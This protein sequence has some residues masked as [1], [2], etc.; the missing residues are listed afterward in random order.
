MRIT[1]ARQQEPRVNLRIRIPKVR[2]IDQNGNQS[3]ILD[4]KDALKMA[5]DAGLDLVEVAP[6]ERPP[7]CRIM[8]YGRFKYQQKK[9]HQKHHGAQ[10]KGIRLSPKIQDHDLLIKAEHAKGFLSRGDKVMVTMQFRGREMT[11]LEIG[12]EIMQKFLEGLGQSAKI[13]K[14]LQMENRRLNV[15]LAPGKIQGRK[16][17]KAQKEKEEKEPKE[18]TKPQA[19]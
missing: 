6:M 19:I 18:Q 12:H 1:I 15:L 5:Q 7:V 14:D 13:E 16:E 11:H 4:T 9:K 8:D 3:G 17:P 10:I 2:V